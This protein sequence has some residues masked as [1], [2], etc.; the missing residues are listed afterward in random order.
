MKICWVDNKSAPF[1]RTNVMWWLP[2]LLKVC[3]KWCLCCCSRFFAGLCVFVGGKN[4]DFMVV[5]CQSKK[6]D[7]FCEKCTDG[8]KKERMRIRAV[9]KNPYFLRSIYTSRFSPCIPIWPHPLSMECHW[10]SLGGLLVTSHLRS[11]GLVRLYSLFFHHPKVPGH[12]EGHWN[13]WGF[14]WQE[15]WGWVL[16]KFYMAKRGGLGRGSLHLFFSYVFFFGL[17]VLVN[18]LFSRSFHDGLPAEPRTPV[19]R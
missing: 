13:L 6:W 16:S 10:V 3:W 11:G 14:E 15:G 18:G 7:F 9:I 2:H 1:H 12:Q 8:G 5:R 17:Q 19:K 4:H